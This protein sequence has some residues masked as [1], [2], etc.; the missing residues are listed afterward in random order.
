MS[1]V[2][3]SYHNPMVLEES[4]VAPLAGGLLQNG[5]QCGILWGAALAAGARA[6]QLLGPGA[7][8]E[9]QAIL[10]T[11]KLVEAFRLRNKEINCSDIIGMRW[12]VSSPRSLAAQVLKFFLRGG[13]LLCFNMSANF[14]EAAFREID[15][16]ST[17]SSAIAPS[18]PESCASLLASRMGASDMHAVL[19]A[20]FAGGIGLSGGACGA[21]GAA[22]WIIS[23]DHAKVSGSNPG[24]ADPLA[25]AAVE[26][27]LAASDNEFECA[28]VISRQF[29]SAADHAAYIQG[30]GCA[31][32]IQALS[33]PA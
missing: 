6:Y 2:D 26:R 31:K 23:M 4:A 18:T 28:R 1:V 24:F 12:K 22:I 29:E 27:Y 30:G 15:R 10:V 13:P 8:A 7:Y 32:I 20:G 21:L 19:A 17:A 11:Q 5:Y 3:C 33:A 25:L 9:T 14:A 16:S